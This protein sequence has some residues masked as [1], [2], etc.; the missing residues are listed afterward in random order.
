MLM[1]LEKKILEQCVISVPHATQKNKLWIL[2]ILV[3][4][5]NSEKFT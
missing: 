1:L 4:K 3:W 2:K 5:L